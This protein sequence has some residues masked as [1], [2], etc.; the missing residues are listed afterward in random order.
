MTKT[1]LAIFFPVLTTFLGMFIT[2]S[3]QVAIFGSLIVTA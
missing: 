2:G 1:Q 3:A